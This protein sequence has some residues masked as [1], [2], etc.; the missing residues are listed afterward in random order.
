MGTFDEN[1]ISKIRE[2]KL[3]GELTDEQWRVLGEELFNMAED[4]LLA[5]EKRVRLSSVRTALGFLNWHEISKNIFIHNI[6]LFD[7][8]ADE[9]N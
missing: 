2:A 5:G 9:K 7:H 1:L 3:T 4:T 8:L 6:V